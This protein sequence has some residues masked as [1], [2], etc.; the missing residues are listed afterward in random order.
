MGTRLCVTPR[1]CPKLP[2]GVRTVGLDKSIIVSVVNQAPAPRYVTVLAIGNKYGITQVLPGN[3]GRDEALAARQ[4]IRT[5]SEQQ[6]LPGETGPLRFVVLSSDRVLNARVLEQ[7][8]TDVVDVQACLSPVARAFCQGADQARAGAW[9]EV[10]D[11]SMAIADAVVTAE[12][13]QP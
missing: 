12:R 5:P 4:A 8:D 2:T 11:W 9:S 6:T 13:V 3:G 10:G 7:T 1:D